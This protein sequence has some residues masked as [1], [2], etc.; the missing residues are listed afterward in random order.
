MAD[1]KEI[2]IDKKLVSKQE[3]VDFLIQKIR[4]PIQLGEI[5]DI[6]QNDSS[7]V[8]VDLKEIIEPKASSVT[9]YLVE[10][11]ELLDFA[12]HLETKPEDVSSVTIDGDNLV[13]T[14]KEKLIAT[15]G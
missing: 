15:F 10:R 7:Y 4:K 8:R 11:K 6:T 13:F 2:K 3:V 9:Y 5:A 14:L 1:A 12:G